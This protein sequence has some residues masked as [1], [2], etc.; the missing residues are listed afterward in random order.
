MT[1]G[2]RIL[3][4]LLFL[5]VGAICLIGLWAF[6]ISRSPFALCFG[7]TALAL[8]ALTFRQHRRWQRLQGDVSREEGAG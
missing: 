5:G 1:R 6:I 7:M 4:V 3:F 2:A 8:A